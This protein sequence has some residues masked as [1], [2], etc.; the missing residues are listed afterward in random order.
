MARRALAVIGM[1]ESSL[2]FVRLPVVSA[3]APN[4]ARHDGAYYVNFA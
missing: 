4:Q 1:V 2:K 3:V